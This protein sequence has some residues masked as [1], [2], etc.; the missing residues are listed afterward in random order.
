MGRSINGFWI[1]EANGKLLPPIIPHI[2]L[3]VSD[4]KSCG[5]DVVLW[6][7][8][9]Q[10]APEEIE[11]IKSLGIIL[12]DHSN[13]SFSSSYQEFLSYLNKGILGDNVALALAA[14]WLR[15]MVKSDVFN[16]KETYV[17]YCQNDGDVIWCANANDDHVISN[18]IDTKGSFRKIAQYFD[19]YHID[20][21]FFLVP[22][23]HENLKIFPW[24]EEILETPIK[25]QDSPPL[26]T[27]MF[28]QYK[29]EHDI[30][31]NTEFKACH[32]Q[33]LYYITPINNLE[34]I[35]K[36]GILS[37][38]RA[39]KFNHADISDNGVHDVPLVA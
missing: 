3:W 18:D 26:K 22:A 27:N 10:I 8:L 37:H 24:Q 9:K 28:F 20:F 15:Y 30:N 38:K 13:C 33:E 16:G 39:A 29:K 6:T 7:N 23:P 32:I 21:S 35:I 12:K 14:F 17:S 25:N 1:T 36:H 4:A 11:R 34:N 31:S 19:D 5:V 2:S